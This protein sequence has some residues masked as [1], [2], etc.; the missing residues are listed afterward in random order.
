MLELKAVQEYVASL[1]E[2]FSKSMEEKS[3]LE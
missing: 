1:K 3:I 2:T